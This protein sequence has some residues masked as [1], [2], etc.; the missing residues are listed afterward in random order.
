MNCILGIDTSNYTTS[1][2]LYDLDS[3]K[4][5][6]T[7]K[8]LLPVRKGEIG[9]RQSEALFHHTLQLPEMIDE[10]MKS[11]PCT[12]SAVSVSSK[13]CGTANS[14]MP[15][16]LAGLSAAKNIASVLHVPVYETTHQKGHILAC[17]YSANILEL[18]S[19][20][21][22]CFHLSGGT[23]QCLYVTPSDYVINAETVAQSLDLKAGQAVDR[24][25]A[26]LGLD[27]PAGSQLDTLASSSSAVFKRKATFKGM[28]CCLSG[29]QNLAEKMIKSGESRADTA[30]FTIDYLL[31]TIME[32]KKRVTNQYGDIPICFAGGVA[33]NTLFRKSLG[34]EKNVYFC[35]PGFSSDNAVGVAVY[36]S[37]KWNS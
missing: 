37:I 18:L 2:A 36:G 4:I 31:N 3:G 17:L 5:A 16:F 29:L 15:C 34:N 8:K 20:P 6:V 10:L 1:A 12:V 33:E 24:I 21:F 11:A 28:D 27:F 32:M 22:L 7:L 35:A 14:Y 9:L 13:P 30:K 23:T 25:G 26:L 19:E